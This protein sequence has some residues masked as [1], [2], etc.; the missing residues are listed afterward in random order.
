MLSDSQHRS[1]VRVGGIVVAL[2]SA[3]PLYYGLVYFVPALR[4]VVP[5]IIAHAATGVGLLVA[6]PGMVAYA[7]VLDRRSAD[8][9]AA[10]HVEY[11]VNDRWERRNL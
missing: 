10:D 2:S 5:A 3:I 4:T 11:G 6:F 9:D 1:V 8:G 7:R